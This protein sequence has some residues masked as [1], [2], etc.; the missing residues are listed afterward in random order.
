MTL[1]ISLSSFGGCGPSAWAFF[2]KIFKAAQTNEH[3][4]IASAQP[5]VLATWNA[6]Y[7]Q[8]NY[9]MRSL[10]VRH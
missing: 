9:N 7:A 10:S 8:T 2:N 5:E 6:F 1:D 4:V 3:G